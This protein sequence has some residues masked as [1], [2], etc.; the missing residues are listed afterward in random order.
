[1]R[2]RRAYAK[3]P[4]VRGL[5][6]SMVAAMTTEGM[7]ASRVIEGAFDFTQFWAYIFD[8]LIPTMNPFPG[9]RSVLVLDNARIHHNP[10]MAERLTLFGIKIE[11][12]PAYSPDFNPIKLSFSQIK[13]YFKR[14]GK[15]INQLPKGTLNQNRFLKDT[16]RLITTETAAKYIQHCGYI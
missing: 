9:P 4:F 6:Y 1:M 12:L 5:K 3:V 2:S 15:I 11:F 16:C 13:A 8:D 14:H 10:A 7:M